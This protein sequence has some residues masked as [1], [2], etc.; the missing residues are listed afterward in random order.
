MQDRKLLDDYYQWEYVDD[1]SDEF[2]INVFIAGAWVI[3]PYKMTLNPD[4]PD[5]E[6]CSVRIDGKLY[7]FG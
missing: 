2:K 1:G 5:S 7:Y 6:C 3:K 4:V